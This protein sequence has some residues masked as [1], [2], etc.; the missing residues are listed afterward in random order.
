MTVLASVVDWEGILEVVI[1]SLVAGIGVTAIFAIA[2]YGATRVL[3][4]SR[5][6]RVLEAGLYGVMAV[7]ALA[8]VLAASAFGIVVMTQK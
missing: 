7:L 8:V 6:G 1:A 4:M 3:D 2:L 5:D